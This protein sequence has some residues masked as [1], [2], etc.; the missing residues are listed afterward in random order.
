MLTWRM[1]NSDW[2][3]TQGF[4]WHKPFHTFTDGTFV[5]IM[6]KG[7]HLLQ[8]ELW[9][10]KSHTLWQP[11][12]LLSQPPLPSVIVT[13]ILL[14]MTEIWIV[15]I[16]LYDYHCKLGIEFSSK[17]MLKA[18]GWLYR[19]FGVALTLA[20]QVSYWASL[21]HELAVTKAATR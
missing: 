3:V 15:E 16:L 7:N 18:F 6:T 13:I 5:T 19:D 9:R 14:T 4:E 10:A 20:Q 17:Y 21:V 12:S 8:Q 11:P 1:A 2:T